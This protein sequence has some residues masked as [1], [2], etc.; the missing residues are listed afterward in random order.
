MDRERPQ[1]T[2]SDKRLE[3]GRPHTEKGKGLSEKILESA[4]GLWRSE[5]H[6]TKHDATSSLSK[7]LASS[8][9]GT[10]S[11]SS[12]SV[13]SRG[14][15]SSIGQ[16]NNTR[17]TVNSSSDSIGE[18]FR[19]VRPPVSDDALSSLSSHSENGFNKPMES[20]LAFEPELGEFSRHHPTSKGKSVACDQAQNLLHQPQDEAILEEAW[21]QSI[22][23]VQSAEPGQSIQNLD[24]VEVLRLLSDPHFDPQHG[25]R[26]EHLHDSRLILS[27]EEN[28]AAELFNG[29]F[30][31]NK[32]PQVAE[33]DDPRS[34]SHS[35]TSQSNTGLSQNFETALSFSI[36]QQSLQ[37]V[38]TFFDGLMNYH[39][40]VWGYAK[41]LVEDVRREVRHASLDQSPNGPALQ[42]LRMILAHAST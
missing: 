2:D 8:E 38:D 28:E 5:V 3:A 21:T 23:S 10:S 30:S 25:T 1:K 9:K 19:S 42:R 6:G 36:E 33:Q 32:D 40:D 31:G 22:L 41:P 37:E 12:S 14:T 20:K 39:E 11:S 18:P 16:E 4:T 27:T 13:W 35:A 26:L 29:Y 15:G 24:G 7:A 17:D 34:S